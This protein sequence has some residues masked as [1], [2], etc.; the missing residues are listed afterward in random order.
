MTTSFLPSTAEVSDRRDAHPLAEP[1]ASETIAPFGQPTGGTDLRRVFATVA[2]VLAASGGLIHLGVIGDHREYRVV[3]AGFAAMGISQCVV[4]L[5]LF[6]RPSTLAF[7]LSAGL[8]AAIGATWAVS[9][10]FGL[11]FI[12]GEAQAAEIGVADL[13]AT[14]FSI[15]VIGVAVIVSAL[16]RSASPTVLPRT[17]ARRMAGSVVVGA[18]LLTAIA[19]SAPHVHDT[20]GPID[21]PGIGQSHDHGADFRAH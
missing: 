21:A 4:A 13:V 16:D 1:V 12:P 3:A 8:H 5:W 17:V 18:L 2:A 10:T 11:W 19:V 20:R 9:R 15:G 14:T 7:L 6:R